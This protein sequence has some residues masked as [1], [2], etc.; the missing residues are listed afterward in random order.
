MAESHWFAE[1][2]QFE[3]TRCGN[4][5]TGSPGSVRVSREEIELLAKDFNLKPKEFRA[6]F[7]RR[8]PDG[9]ISL[10]E[11]P[12]RDCV[13]WDQ[14]RGLHRICPAAAAMSH[15]ALLARQSGFA[16]ALGRG[17]QELPGHERRS[18]AL[19]RRNYCRLA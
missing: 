12:N 2:L 5:C 10:I 17:G 18:P 15:L 3:C 7:T 8:L 1:G 14:E 9:A 19:R 13:F 6:R 4:C 16:E 11:K